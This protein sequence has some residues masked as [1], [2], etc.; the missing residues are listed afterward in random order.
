MNTFQYA[1]PETVEE[2]LALLHEYGSAASLL[3]GGTDLL[4]RLRKGNVK[5]RLVIDL[6]R[7]T[8]LRPDIIETGSCLEI[9]ARAVLTDVIQDER[10]QRHFPALAEAARTVGSVQIRNRATLAGNICNA[11]PAA[12]T[13]PALLVYG[14]RVNLIGIKGSRR[15][16][17]SEFFVGP[18]QTVLQ[19]SEIV[20]SI[21]LPRPQKQ[22]GAAFTRL[23]RRRGVDL[24][25]LNACCLVDA[26]GVTRF[27]YGAVGPRPLLVA[28]ESG[29]LADPTADEQEKEQVLKQLIAQASPISDV[30]ASREYRLAMLFVLS[31]RALQTALKRLSALAQGI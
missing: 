12:D 11:S 8:T 3:T 31:R 19:Q 16:L 25:T 15:V 20:V 30:R 6:K 18:G 24:A 5:P 7:V 21:E 29:C 9:G 26:A 28:D 23:T 1:R 14:A 17:L 4:V 10:V 22:I 2:V 13:A 27:A